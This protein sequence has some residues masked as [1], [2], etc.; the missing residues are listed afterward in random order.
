MGRRARL[1]RER[2]TAGQRTGVDHLAVLRHRCETIGAT[3][4]ESPPHAAKMSDTLIDFARPL[5][6]ALG[7]EGSLTMD[8]FES[9]LSLAGVVWNA[10]LVDEKDPTSVEETKRQIENLTDDAPL[11]RGIFEELTERRRRL[12]AHDRRLLADLVVEKSPIKGFRVS[13]AS[14][15]G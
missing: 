4:I 12:F 11:L 8:R 3:V 9:A 13:A 2:K 15:P 6:D 14:A 7:R 10:Y 5:L 1:K